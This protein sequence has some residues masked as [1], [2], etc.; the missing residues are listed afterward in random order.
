MP[1]RYHARNQVKQD[2]GISKQQAALLVYHSEFTLH[3]KQKYAAMRPAANMVRKEMVKSNT[4]Y[5]T[6]LICFL[7]DYAAA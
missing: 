2:G 6:N 3:L 4:D 1:W 5:V 7:P